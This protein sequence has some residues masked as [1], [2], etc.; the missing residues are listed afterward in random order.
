MATNI[1]ETKKIISLSPFFFLD[2]RF[3]CR[4]LFFTCS[5]LYV[6]VVNTYE[7]LI[8]IFQY[9]VFKSLHNLNYTLYLHYSCICSTFKPLM[10]QLD[11]LQDKKSLYSHLFSKFP[12]YFSGLT[13]HK[14]RFF[15]TCIIISSS[16]F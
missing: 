14:P 15:I 5:I 6:M 1:M 8:Y 13:A 7:Y 11:Y 12:L 2:L 4:V 9:F 16:I 3:L 10:R